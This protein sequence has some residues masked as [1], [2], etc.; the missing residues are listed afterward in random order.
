MNA[1]AIS[2]NEKIENLIYEVR[3][4]QVMLDS[5]ISV[6]KCNGNMVTHYDIG[7]PISSCNYNFADTFA[8]LL[9]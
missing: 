3:G 9:R 8:K 6:T 5:E 1:L 7:K 4:K 2:E